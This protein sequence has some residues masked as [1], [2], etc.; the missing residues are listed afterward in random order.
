VSTVGTRKFTYED[1]RAMP[2]DGKRYEL[3]EGEVYMSPSPRVKHQKV[4][5]RLFRALAQFVEDSDLGEVFVAPLDVVLDDQN[6]VQPDVLFVG[7]GKS[8]AITPLFING[9]PDLVV[10]VLSPSNAE[11]DRTTKRRAYAGAGVPEIWYVDPRDDSIEVLRLGADRVHVLVR[12]FTGADVLVSDSFPGL[13]LPLPT[14]F[15]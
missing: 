5:G 15:I 2:Q 14:I 13:E 12:R 6:V 7:R 9:P 1:L 10:E 8:Q 11:F 3:L 4:L